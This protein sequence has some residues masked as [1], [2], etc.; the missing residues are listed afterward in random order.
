MFK[1][2]ANESA[3]LTNFSINS[4][5]EG[6]YE[7]EDKFVLTDLEKSRILS[8]G[9]MGDSVKEVKNSLLGFL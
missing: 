5:L 7:N 4:R 2:S 6:E 1:R 9:V 8:V 3:N